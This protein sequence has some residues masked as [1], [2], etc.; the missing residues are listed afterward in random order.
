MWS[1]RNTKNEH[2]KNLF[3]KLGTFAIV[4]VL[5]TSVVGCGNVKDKSAVTP[6]ESVSTESTS[7]SDDSTASTKTALTEKDISPFMSLT[8][9]SM[10]HTS[11][12]RPLI[13][14]ILPK[15]LLSQRLMQVIHQSR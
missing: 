8:T 15:L 3:K 14:K 10:R 5:S 6:K 2:K 9:M 11:R 7:T 13:R 1:L 4:A 12:I